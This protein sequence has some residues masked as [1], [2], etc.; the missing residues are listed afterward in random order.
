MPTVPAASQAFLT[1]LLDSGDVVV[2]SR[3]KPDQDVVEFFVA[4]QRPFLFMDGFALWSMQQLNAS[5]LADLVAQ[6]YRTFKH[7]GPVDEPEPAPQADGEP[8][9]DEA[10]LT[11]DILRALG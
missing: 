6:A 8:E 10:A 5:H 1:I 9:I 2:Y 7:P 11:A 4:G 3:I